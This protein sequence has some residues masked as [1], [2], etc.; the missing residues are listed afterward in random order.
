MI[1]CFKDNETDLQNEQ[2]KAEKNASG[3][4]NFKVM[5]IPEKPSEDMPRLGLR[6]TARIHGEPVSLFYYLFRRPIVTF[7][8]LTGV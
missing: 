3:I 4:A 8:Q 6:G 5:A 2:D 1:H 7:R